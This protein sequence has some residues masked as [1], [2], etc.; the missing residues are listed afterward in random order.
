M[1]D[2]IAKIGEL[3]SDEESVKQ[4]SELAQMFMSGGSESGESEEKGDK[5]QLRAKINERD[6]K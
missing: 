1:D 5:S 6:R 3:L 4:L 2:T